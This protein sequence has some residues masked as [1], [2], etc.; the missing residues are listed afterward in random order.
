MDRADTNHQEKEIRL[1]PQKI[2]R[3]GKCNK[4]ESPML[5]D[6]ILTPKEYWLHRQKLNYRISKWGANGIL[7]SSFMSVSPDEESS[8]CTLPAC[9]A[10][11]QPGL[12]YNVLSVHSK[13]SHFFEGSS[14]V[15]RP[16]PLS[17][18]MSC[19]ILAYRPSLCLFCLL[20][21]PFL[22]FED[23]NQILP[24]LYFPLSHGYCLLTS[25]WR[26]PDFVGP[27]ACVTHEGAFK[28]K[29]IKTYIPTQQQLRPFASVWGKLEARKLELRG[30]PTSDFTSMSG[31]LESIL[32]L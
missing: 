17:P 23:G 13:I 21:W 29:T 9:Q 6:L 25:T 30:K 8:H 3:S 7:S 22:S 16:Q 19:S 12:P 31:I 11:L 28:R 18:L 5:G 20:C 2:S 26:C 24:T 27:E 10:P 15:T 4:R 1:R 32:S 14:P